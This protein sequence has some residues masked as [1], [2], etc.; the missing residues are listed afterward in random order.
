MENRCPICKVNPTSRGSH[1][2]AP[3]QETKETVVLLAMNET[4]SKDARFKET[5]QELGLR[6]IYPPFWA[7]L[8]H[9][10]IFQSFTPDL[11]HQLHKGVFKDHLVKWCTNLLTEK[12]LDARFKSMTPYQGLRHFKNGIS[13]VSQ[14]TGAEHKAMEKVF[15]SVVA[16]AIN[17]RRVSQ[18]ARAVVDFIF[19]SSLQS[20]TT[21]SLNALSQ[22]LDD[23]HTYKDVFIEL[24]ARQ[25]GHFNIPKIHSMEHYLM[26][27][28][29]FGS[30]D[31]FNTES[32]ERLHIDYAKNAY[33]ASNKRD[34][35]IQ[36]TNW[37]RRQEAVDRF[38]WY[39]KWIRQGGYEA[40]EKIR[41]NP[42][43]AS[44][45]E[46]A[47]AVLPAASH[48]PQPTTSPTNS[49]ITYQ[50]ASTLPPALRGIPAQKIIHDHNAT[51]FMPAV[52]AFL[53]KDSSP[54]TAHLFD[55]FDLY[56]RITVRLPN[57]PQANANSL[58][59][60]IRATPP[61][62]AHNRAPAEPPCL[63]FALIRTGERNDKTDATA[64]RGMCP[65][66]C[67]LYG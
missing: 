34:Y 31:G 49:Q 61:V 16:G 67:T 59:D 52:Q 26:L 36:M 17:D 20:H 54:I 40:T 53:N 43:S 33:R 15:V 3:P 23:F 58:V 25:P 41:S 39:L 19:Y 64:L 12:E 6:P 7:R 2:P 37:L 4:N 22:S 62:P 30:A 5:Y 28:K 27:I 51:Q 60:V 65:Y 14:W 29:L 47:I 11:L 32:P 38:T 1:E 18:A 45:H 66:L 57:I 50:I 8:P 63:D 46:T 44:L 9:C 48:T 55:G 35:T 13:S 56:K 42:L 21:Q 24:E 10:D